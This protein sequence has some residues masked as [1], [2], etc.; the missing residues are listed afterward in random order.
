MSKEATLR[1]SAQPSGDH[2]AMTAA[3]KTTQARTRT[4]ALIVLSI[5]IVTTPP[6][7]W[8]I[9]MNANTQ[10]L[11]TSE[12]V[13][14]WRSA[15]N[16]GTVLL[17]EDGTAV[18]R[19]VIVRERVFVT[20]ELVSAEIDNAEGSWSL[21]ANETE[22]DVLLDEQHDGVQSLQ[23]F[24]ERPLFQEMHLETIASVDISGGERSF[25]RE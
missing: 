25:I 24:A 8:G 21:G 13:G 18:I 23:L 12:V 15:E 20:Q 9:E 10:P 3:S 2:R 7:L 1:P 4:A 14:V 19:H 16:G 5:A 22:V 6:I 11:N 17:S